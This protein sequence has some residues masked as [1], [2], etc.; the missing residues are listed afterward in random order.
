MSP[1]NNKAITVLSKV[2]ARVRKKRETESQEEWEHRL[3]KNAEYKTMNREVKPPE[4]HE[5]RTKMQ[6]ITQKEG[7]SSLQNSARIDRNKMQ[8]IPK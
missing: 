3:K 5:K 2:A 7:Q 4:Q 6:K 1:N 8:N